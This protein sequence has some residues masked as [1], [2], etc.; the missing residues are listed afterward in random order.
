MCKLIGYV[1]MKKTEGKV[2]FVTDSG[3]SPV[4]GDTCDKVFVYGDLSKKITNG[5]VGHDVSFV[6]GCGYNGKAFVS[7]VII[8]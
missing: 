7:D 1:E 5:C 6:Y 3:K 4:V 2:C 8:K